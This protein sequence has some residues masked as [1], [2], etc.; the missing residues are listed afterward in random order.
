MTSRFARGPKMPSTYV[1][2]S[3]SPTAQLDVK[4]VDGSVIAKAV[5]IVDLA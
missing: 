3:A 1:L 2:V 5:L 4:M